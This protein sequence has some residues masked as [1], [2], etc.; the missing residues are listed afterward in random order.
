MLRYHSHAEDKNEFMILSH[1]CEQYVSGDPVHEKTV[2]NLV[3]HYSQYHIVFDGEEAYVNDGLSTFHQ[4][5]YQGSIETF[6][7]IIRNKMDP[8]HAY[9]QGDFYVS[10]DRIY[11]FTLSKCFDFSKPELS[12]RDLE[13]LKMKRGPFGLPREFSFLI[14]SITI[15]QIWL[16]WVMDYNSTLSFGLSF[17][18]IGL[19]SFYYYKTDK[20]TRMEIY[21][22]LFLGISFLLFFLGSFHYRHFY[23]IYF[24]VTL[25]ILVVGSFYSR[26]RDALSEYNSY[27]IDGLE[28]LDK[29][30]LKKQRKAI[31]IWMDLWS[32]MILFIYLNMYSAKLDTIS[33]TILLII[34]IIF[35]AVLLLTLFAINGFHTSE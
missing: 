31:V 33:D 26:Q 10:G 8:F 7:S 27:N 20:L 16:G 22:L 5:E 12:E 23:N 30:I 6:I 17:L 15:L 2:L 1:I 4:I 3:F 35:C 19:F 29:E 21:L 14:S 34:S 25:P 13:P 32:L 28:I 24:I 11:F 18:I 9:G